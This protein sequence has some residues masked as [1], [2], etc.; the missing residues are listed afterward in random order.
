M[1]SE[2][3]SYYEEGVKLET[4]GDVAGAFEAFR[5]SAKANPRIAAPYVGLARI[6]TR[7]RQRKDAISCLERAVSCEPTNVSVRTIL[8]Q[9]LAEDGQLEASQTAFE[10][11]L[12]VTPSA[13]AALLGLGSVYEDLGD[14]AAATDA[15]R[16]LLLAHPDNAEGLAGLLTVTGGDALNDAV[17]EAHA[18]LKKADDQDAALIGY[19]LGKALARAGDTDGAFDA[20]SAANE[21]RCRDAG[22]FD[23]GAF[24]R[25]IERLCEI[26][27]SHFFED[28]RG[29]G[30]Q[31]DRSVFVVGLPRSGTTLTEQILSAHGQVYGAGELDLLTD[32]ATGL[33]DRLGRANPPWPDAA[34]DL[35]PSH[36]RGIGRDY[37]GRIAQLAPE[38]ASRVIDKQPLNF[39]NLGL[40]A[41]AL[42][43]ARI[44][45]CR[46]DIRDCGLSIFSENFTPDQRWATDLSNIAHYWRGYRRLMQ[47]WRDVSSL[48][49]L[50]MN[51]EDL[52]IDLEGQSRRLLDFVD[53]PWDQSVLDFH[54]SDRAVQTPSRWQVRQPL[55]QSSRGRWRTYEARLGP[56]IAAAEE[57]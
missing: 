37:L 27:S 48:R 10:A 11:V 9:T 19:A 55:Y 43:N 36:V 42:P 6:L 2:G 50:D 44:V 15:Y 20:L 45:H 1:S 57:A 25:R 31:S 22:P 53:L 21:A 23:R 49:I 13:P 30:E 5:R 18:Q 38:T 52:V 14:R 39:W 24:D 35:T 3:Q 41:A 56:L 16:Q 51:Y 32:L 7:N 54:T 17:R 33:P 46:R 28:R 4:S 29:G 40:V 8:G 12:N 34:A 26:F 47:H